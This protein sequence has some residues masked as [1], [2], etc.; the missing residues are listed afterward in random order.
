MKR[1]LVLACLFS[2]GCAVTKNPLGPSTESIVPV[3]VAA[4]SPVVPTPV[5]TPD[6][7]VSPAP[8]VAPPATPDKPALPP[9]SA[10]TLP[11]PPPPTIVTCVKPLVPTLHNG[12]VVCEMPVTPPPPPP[13]WQINQCPTGTHPHVDAA[14]KI[15]CVKN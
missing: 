10:P 14:G 11:T 12:T 1:L 6:P 15:T 7:V 5:V 2:V 3:S 13:I 4:T 9:P 8:V